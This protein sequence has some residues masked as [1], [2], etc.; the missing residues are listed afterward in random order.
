[1]PRLPQSG[2]DSGTWGDLLNEFLLVAHNADGTL[3]IASA[4]AEKYTLPSTGIP[5]TDLSA[6]VQSSLSAADDALSTDDIDTDVELTT[7]SDTRVP[8]QKAV[9]TYIDQ[10]VGSTVNASDAMAWAIAL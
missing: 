10:K 7:N 2:S 8:S 5:K 9:K 3:K 4:V 1:M 6:T